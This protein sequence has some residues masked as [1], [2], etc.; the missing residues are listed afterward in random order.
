[1]EIIEVPINQ[2]KA[3][4]YNP[5]AM[6]AQPFENLQRSLDT[7]GMPQPI[8][9]N[10]RNQ[11]IVGGHQ[12]WQA[13]KALAW[14]KVPV[15]YVDLDERE[16]RKFNVMLN[17]PKFQGVFDTDMLAEVLHDMEAEDLADLDYTEEEVE[18]M[19]DGYVD[20]ELDDDEVED[21]RAPK[22]KSYT[23]EE[24]SRLAHNYYA[25]AAAAEFVK[26][27]P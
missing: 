11:T 24:L 4:D 26:W 27:L 6:D 23:K 18:T 14:E 5:R 13:A 20:H 12:R 3:A 25:P 1:M 21:Q 10:K 8:V 19:Q 2:I 16:E 17:S 15:I 7:F 22:A 9:V